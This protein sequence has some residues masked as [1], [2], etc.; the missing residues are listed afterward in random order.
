MSSTW[1]SAASLPSKLVA[2][3]GRGVH[4]ELVDVTFCSGGETVHTL[5]AAMGV[6]RP[7]LDVSTA[8]STG[9][10]IRYAQLSVCSCGH[11]FQT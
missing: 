4:H 2:E 3:Y 11:L 6:K 5:P 1:E 7:R 9:Y 8:V 10:V